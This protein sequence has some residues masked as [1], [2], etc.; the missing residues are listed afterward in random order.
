[1]SG[2]ADHL[3]LDV[4]VLAQSLEE[5][6]F[7]IQLVQRKIPYRMSYM[8]RQDYKW[9][10]NQHSRQQLQAIKPVS[11]FCAAKLVIVISYELSSLSVERHTKLLFYFGQEPANVYF[12]N[13]QQQF[14][15]LLER[16]REVADSDP[17][18]HPISPR[19]KK[20]AAGAD[21]VRSSMHSVRAT[22][23]QFGPVTDT[24]GA[25][26]AKSSTSTSSLISNDF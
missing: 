21:L 1:M 25:T 16:T 5:Q 23:L 18:V 9:Q 22:S 11:L 2:D 19:A 4:A 17:S 6:E 3:T 7:F 20:E 26:R 10:L 15:S 14:R 8:L 24:A 12:A 13:F